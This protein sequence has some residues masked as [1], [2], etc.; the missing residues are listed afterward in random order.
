MLQGM[1]N[2]RKRQREEMASEP[3]DEDL[4]SAAGMMLHTFQQLLLSNA[5]RNKL[6]QV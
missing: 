5:A 2:L 1:E 4:A 3:N 6:I